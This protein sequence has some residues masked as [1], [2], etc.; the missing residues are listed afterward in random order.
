MNP[1]RARMVHWRVYISV[2]SIINCWEWKQYQLTCTLSNILDSFHINVAKV[3]CQLYA[4][5]FKEKPDW[6]QIFLWK[7]IRPTRLKHILDTCR[8]TCILFKK[9]IMVQ[10]CF[11]G[12]HL[13][14]KH[15]DL[16]N[17]FKEA[18][19]N[20][21]FFCFPEIVHTLHWHASFSMVDWQ[22]TKLYDCWKH[23]SKWAI[24]T[25]PLS[26][27]DLKSLTPN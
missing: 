7:E 23:A 4:N 22:A 19:V 14:S 16:L 1:N 17:A 15:L 21:T 20:L 13:S 8:P 11:L 26:S 9:Q 12:A 27:T 6:N 10:K 24:W 25:E 5:L 18:E 3:L 2:C